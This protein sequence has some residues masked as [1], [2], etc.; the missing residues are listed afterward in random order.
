MS[1]LTGFTSVPELNSRGGQEI[2]EEISAQNKV[3]QA[4]KGTNIG[5]LVSNARPGKTF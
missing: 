4:W 3:K 2:G 1:A 5:L